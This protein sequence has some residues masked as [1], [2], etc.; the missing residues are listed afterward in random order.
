MKR[1]GLQGTDLEVSRLSFGTASLHHL[2]SG[3]LRQNLLAA[4]LDQGF[5]H[6]DTSPYYGF[7][8]AEQELGRFLWEKRNQVTLATKVGLYAPGS[9]RQNIATV[10]LRKGLGKVIPRLSRP[11]VDWSVTHAARS[12]QSSLRRLRTEFVDILFLHE[13][14]PGVLDSDEFLTWLLEE[15]RKGSIRAWGLAGQPEAMEE[16]I[17][18]SHP[19]GAVLQ[20]RDSLDHLEADRVTRVGRELQITFGYLSSTSVSAG[21]LWPEDVLT[22]ALERNRTGSVLVSTRRV[23]RIA[24]LASTSSQKTQ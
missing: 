9:L 11:L 24:K 2:P 6:F 16:W 1:I 19:L 7:G 13:P 23:E 18:P 15:K 5:T 8:L 20:V 12:L 22:R 3:R 4:A 14:S 17:R 21:Q 10:W